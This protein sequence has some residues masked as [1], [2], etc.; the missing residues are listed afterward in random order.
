MKLGKDTSSV[1][2]WVLSGS[3]TEPK[4]GGFAVF[5]RWTD[6]RSEEIT[7]IEEGK[8]TLEDGQTLVFK[9]GKW[10]SFFESVEFCGKFYSEFEEQVKVLGYSEAHKAILAPLFEN[11]GPFLSLVKGKTR[12]KKNY[13]KVNIT[14]SDERDDYTDPHF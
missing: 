4:V 14:F 9:N 8:I 11:G 2:N 3:K 10:Y 12:K 5:L 6:R 7:A 13:N 1:I